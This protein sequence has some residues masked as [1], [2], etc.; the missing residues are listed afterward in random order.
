MGA[1]YLVCSLFS[2]YIFLWGREHGDGN[3][4]AGTWGWEQFFSD[5]LFQ[6]MFF[7]L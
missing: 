7:I 5:N 2:D 1:D 3:L 6:K 4:S